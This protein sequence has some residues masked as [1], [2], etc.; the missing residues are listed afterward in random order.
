MPSGLPTYE[1]ARSGI[2][3]RSTRRH[4]LDDVRAFRTAYL[5]E[6]SQSSPALGQFFIE[7]FADALG[8]HLANKLVV[9]TGAEEG[10]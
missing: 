5:A 4:A 2:Q 6:R 1:S 8:R 7:N 3:C 10:L 9:D